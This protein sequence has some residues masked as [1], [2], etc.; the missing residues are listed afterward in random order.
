V[1][2]LGLKR[3]LDLA[4]SN[5]AEELYLVQ[6]SARTSLEEVVRCRAG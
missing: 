3:A 5:I 2:L 4:P 1:V 6:E